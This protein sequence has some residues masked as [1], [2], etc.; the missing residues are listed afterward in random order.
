MSCKGDEECTKET[1]SYTI[2]HSYSSMK[3]RQP[4]ICPGPGSSQVTYPTKAEKDEAVKKEAD[5]LYVKDVKPECPKGCACWY[6][7]KATEVFNGTPRISG[8]DIV[9][10][11]GACTYTFMTFGDLKVTHII[12][13]GRCYFEGIKLAIIDDVQDFLVTSIDAPF[14]VSSKSVIDLYRA[15]LKSQ[16][17]LL[18]ES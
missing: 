1:M 4:S 18:S 13:H 5:K 11:I 15:S 17:E 8:E 3:S 2:T 9:K 14:I 10:V 12:K 16:D 6:N 7:E